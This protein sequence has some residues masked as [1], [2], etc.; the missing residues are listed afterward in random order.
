MGLAE[1]V[2]KRQWRSASRIGNQRRSASPANE[3]PYIERVSEFR[4][5]QKA[6][7]EQW[8]SLQADAV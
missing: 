7:S 3:N 1:T 4:A 6:R 8:P 5:G 2:K